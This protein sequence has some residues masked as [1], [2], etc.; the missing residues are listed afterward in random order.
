MPHI[1][2][3]M[4]MSYVLKGREMRK[5][6]LLMHTGRSSILCQCHVCVQFVMQ[7]YTSNPSALNETFTGCIVIVQGS[8]VEEYPV[9]K[10]AAKENLIS[11][12]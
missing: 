9:I 10:R 7:V 1:K 12:N 5:C 11:W 8:E 6:R 2:C 4:F 3:I